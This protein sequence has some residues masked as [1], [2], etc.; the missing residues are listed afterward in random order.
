MIIKIIKSARETGELETEG[1]NAKKPPFGQIFESCFDLPNH[2]SKNVVKTDNYCMKPTRESLRA[3]LNEVYQRLIDCN[4][5]SEEPELTMF[6]IALLTAMGR[7][8]RGDHLTE[9]VLMLA[10]GESGTADRITNRLMRWR[11]GEMS[12]HDMAREQGLGE[13]WDYRLGEMPMP[14]SPIPQHSLSWDQ[15]YHSMGRPH[16]ILWTHQVQLYRQRR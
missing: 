12:G 7:E 11:R 4:F 10:F 15:K 2:Y 8:G 9:V 16:R 13:Q 5:G 3:T 14:V 6:I 1:E